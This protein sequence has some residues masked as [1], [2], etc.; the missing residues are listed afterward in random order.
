[1]SN[2]SAVLLA[3]SIVG[4]DRLT[5]WVVDTNMYVGESIGVIPGFFALTYVRWPCP[6]CSIVFRSRIAGSVVQRRL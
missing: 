5:K 2:L 1:M 6:G 4:L 3:L